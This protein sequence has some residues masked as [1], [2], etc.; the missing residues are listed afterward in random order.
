M[1]RADYASH[2]E[3]LSVRLRGARRLNVTSATDALARL[4]IFEHGVLPINIVLCLKVIR[5]GGSPMKVQGR[6]NLELFHITSPR[7]S[8]I[9]V[10][11][12]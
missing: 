5:V 8:R 10:K 2:N 1:A 4:R 12:S 6:S 9:E 3:A 7:P 11:R